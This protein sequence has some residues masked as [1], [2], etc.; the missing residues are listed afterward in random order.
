M[1]YHH[2]MNDILIQIARTDDTRDYPIVFGHY[3][4]L[5]TRP[6]KDLAWL[7]LFPISRKSLKILRTSVDLIPTMPKCQPHKILSQ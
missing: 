3:P 4:P 5:P 7:D 6:S 1:P 2:E